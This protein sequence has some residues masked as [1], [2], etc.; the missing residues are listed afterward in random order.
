MT[1]QKIYENLKAK[2]GESIIEARLDAPQPWIRIAAD[3]TKEI[4]FFLAMNG[5]SNLII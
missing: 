3:K 4:C 2:F 1:S 5:H